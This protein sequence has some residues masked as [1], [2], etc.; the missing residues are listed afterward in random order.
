MCEHDAP[1]FP[2]FVKGRK[3]SLSIVDSMVRVLW[4]TMEGE[5]SEKTFEELR[6]GV[7]AMQKY[8]IKS[9][10]IRA[11]VYQHPELFERVETKPVIRWRLTKRAREGKRE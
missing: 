5:W 2:E 6:S 11:T 1:K 7:A 8:R 9:S 10:T 4:R 3:G